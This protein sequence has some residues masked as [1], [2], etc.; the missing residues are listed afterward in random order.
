MSFASEGGPEF[1]AFP[2]IVL[3]AEGCPYGLDLID[4]SIERSEMPSRKSKE[5]S[6]PNG[7]GL[8]K[9]VARASLRALLGYYTGLFYKRCGV[10]V[11]TTT[12]LLY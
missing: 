4:M 6:E 12:P 3:L 9:R 2:L 11:A 10:V 1:L 8:F 5:M 7:R